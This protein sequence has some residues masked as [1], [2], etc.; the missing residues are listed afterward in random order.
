LS[1]SIVV[2]GKALSAAHIAT[3]IFVMRINYVTDIQKDNKL[4]GDLVIF[5]PLLSS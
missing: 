2:C 1:C 3:G 5:I 4:S